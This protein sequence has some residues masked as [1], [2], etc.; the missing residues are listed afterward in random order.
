ML[1]IAAKQNYDLLKQSKCTCL[2]NKGAS[3]KLFNYPIVHRLQRLIITLLVTI[4]TYY[5]WEDLYNNKTCQGIPVVKLEIVFAKL[6]DTPSN[7]FIGIILPKKNL[8]EWSHLFLVEISEL[9]LLELI[10]VSRNI[11]K[12]LPFILPNM[13]Y[14]IFAISAMYK[15]TSTYGRYDVPLAFSKRKESLSHPNTVESV[16]PWKFVKIGPG[17]ALH[18]LMGTDEGIFFIPSLKF[19]TTRSRTSDLRV[20]PEFPN[21]LG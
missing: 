2:Q 20:L 4:T 1:L 8:Q 6:Y 7:P 3:K 5:H 18:W 12:C 19:A 17:C 16:A 10:Q 9:V 15:K 11:T 21:H 13:C 14:I